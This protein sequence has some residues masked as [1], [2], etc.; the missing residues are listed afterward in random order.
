MRG[1]ALQ[2]LNDADVVVYLTDATE[3]IPPP[4]AEAAGARIA[5]STHVIEA[6]NKIDA[7]PAGSL[8]QIR[9]ARPNARPISAVTGQGVD[10]LLREV[11]AHLPESPFLYP[12][13]D[14]GTQST[15]FFVAELVRETALEQLHEEVPYSVAC[16]VEEFREDRD[17][18]YIRAVVYVERESQ[19]RILIGH[20]G[21]Q[22]REL[23]RVSR[24]KIEDL[25]G[26]SVY[27]DLWV[28]VLP[29]WRRSPRDL[30]RFGFD[31]PEDL[32]T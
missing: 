26:Q 5:S 11:A 4:L 20:K 15:R 2:A 1:I 27:L 30:K 12:E 17:P 31:L 23:G 6:L 13:D 19:K 29:N 22:I 24:K 9:A 28:K 10:E 14:I 7:I 18:W 16:E 8:E 21:S 32:R 3:G 25:V